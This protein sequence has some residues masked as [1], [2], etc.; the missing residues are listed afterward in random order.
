MPESPAMRPRLPPSWPALRPWAAGWLLV[1]LAG[2]LLLAALDRARDREAFDNQGRIV[3]RLLSQRAAQHDA[4]LATLALLQ[5]AAGADGLQR[6]TALYPQILAVRRLGPGEDWTDP[7]WGAAQAQS[8]QAR[9]PVAVQVDA[10]A[11]RLWLLQAAEP[12]SFA[13]QVDLRAALPWAE[14]PLP[15]EGAVRVALLLEGAP[16]VLQAGRDAPSLLGRF[17]LR[18]PLASPSQP[19]TLELARDLGWAEL[20]WAA[21]GAWAIAAAA[22]AAA[23]A[24]WQG[25]RAARRRAEELLR[26]GQVARLNTLGELAAGLAHELNQPLTAVLASTQAARRLLAEEP[27]ELEPARGAMEQAAT[28]ARRASEVVARLRRGIERPGTQPTQPVLLQDAVRNAFDLLA[29]EFA[30]RQVTP[31]L[32]GAQP[33]RVQAEPVALE[34]IVHNLLLNALQALE[35]VPPHERALDVDVVAGPQGGTLTVADSGPGIPPELLPRIFE[36]FVTTRAQG[37][38]LGLPLCESLAGAMG[39]SLQAQPRA[40]RG[41][42]FRL[43]LPVAA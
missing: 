36:P 8:R 26:L 39:G 15:R 16:L 17:T 4:V 37:L 42:A 31:R 19:A 33:V 30:R 2:A 21:M 41:A 40:P 24:A 3:H 1:A 38:G 35:Q 12:A 20:P 6:L 27:P 11:G 32:Q 28:Q 22:L 18:K 14:W 23:G 5:P 10:E 29:P 13:L 7:A 43:T 9:R 25:Q 34:Q